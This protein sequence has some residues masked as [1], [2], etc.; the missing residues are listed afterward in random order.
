MASSEPKRLMRWFGH[1]PLRTVLRIAATIL[2]LTATLWLLSAIWP[3]PD[4]AA[5][6]ADASEDAPTSLA[7]YPLAPVTVLLVG[8]DSDQVGD[9]LNQAAPKGA[10]NADALMLLRI[11]ASTALQVLQIPIELAVQLPGS[12]EP[13]TLASLWQ[14]GG[15]ALVNDA[16]REI[17]G[18]PIDQ[19]QRYVVMPRSVLRSLVDEMGEVE[20]VLG[21][22]Y[23]RKDKAQNY[24]VNLQ[25][26]R[27]TLNGAQAEQLV[28]YLKDP[29]DDPN[30][31]LRQQLLMQAAVDQL[32]TPGVLVRMPQLMDG[33]RDQVQ[34]NLT[35]PEMLSLTAALV[36]SPSPVKINQLP[37]AERAGEQVLR[38]IKPGLTPPLWPSP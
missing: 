4:R 36:A 29:R 23:K 38:Q 8:I 30:R 25:A 20:V 9:S 22:S 19:P 6:G 11:D 34:T 26:G 1:H 7:A 27:Q 35:K 3:E 31:R 2:G 37:L 33:I 18:L 5:P 12:K 21:Q 13:S 15:V 24:S 17:V 10:A 32:R 16:I 28:R 14:V